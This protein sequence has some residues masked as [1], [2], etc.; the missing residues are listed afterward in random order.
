M[1][2]KNANLDFIICS[3]PLSGEAT[4]TSNTLLHLCTKLAFTMGTT[5]L[6][7]SLD[8]TPTP[9]RRCERVG[10]DGVN[11]NLDSNLNLDLPLSVILS[12]NCGGSSSSSSI[13][14]TNSRTRTSAVA[15]AVQRVAPR[16]IEPRASTPYYTTPSNKGS[17]DGSYRGLVSDFRLSPRSRSRPVSRPPAES[18]RDGLSREGL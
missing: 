15:V 3:H 1:K 9:S 14:N 2:S 13:T 6:L 16:L 7:A 17:G 10:G 11:L 8:Y 5:P 18:F 12:Q 4:Y